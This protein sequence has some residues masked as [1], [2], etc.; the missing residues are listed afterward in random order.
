MEGPNKKRRDRDSNT[1]TARKFQILAADIARLV[2]LPPSPSSMSSSET[3]AGFLEKAQTFVAENKRAVLIGSAAAAL[4]VGGALYFAS[5]SRPGASDIEKGGKK[6][7]KGGKKR[8]TVKDK[9]GPILEERKPK[10]AP[11]EGACI[12]T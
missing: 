7:K 8:K 3:S 5:T 2:C 10:A 4:A 11:E 9:D 6:S 1:P 12:M